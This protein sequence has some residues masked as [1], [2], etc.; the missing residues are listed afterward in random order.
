MQAKRQDQELVV[1]ARNRD[2]KVVVDALLKVMQHGKAMRCCK[3]DPGLGQ[4]VYRQGRTDGMNGHVWHLK[5][6]VCGFH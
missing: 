5:K 3:V 4:R 2:G 6:S 1:A